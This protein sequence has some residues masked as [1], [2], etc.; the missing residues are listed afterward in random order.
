MFRST[1][2]S[3][4]LG[5]RGRKTG[6][7]LNANVD[8]DAETG[9]PTNVDDLGWSDS[10]SEE[11]E[12]E[13]EEEK[14]KEM[15]PVRKAQLPSASSVS[16]AGILPYSG[17]ALPAKARSTSRES[18]SPGHGTTSARTRTRI[19]RKKK[20]ESAASDTSHQA[21]DTL[22]MEQG[23][24]GLDR[25][26]ERGEE[27]EEDG[28]LSRPL[29]PQGDDSPPSRPLTTLSKKGKGRKRGY[30]GGSMKDPLMKTASEIIEELPSSPSDST[31]GGSVRMSKRRKYAP[32]EWWRNERPIM[33]L[34]EEDNVVVPSVEK[35]VRVPK[36][37]PFHPPQRVQS[38]PSTRGRGRPRKVGRPV[39]IPVLSS[40][41]NGDQEEEK[42]V[43]FLP[44]SVQLKAVQHGGFLFQN[45]FVQQDLMT[46]GV[47]EIPKDGLKPSRN[48]S[49]RVMVYHII[50]GLVEVTLHRTTFALGT[51]AHFFIPPMNQ[52]Q[53][54]NVGRVPCR[55]F[56]CNIYDAPP[57]SEVTTTGPPPLSIK[58]GKGSLGKKGRRMGA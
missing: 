13:E 14:E 21:W 38:A 40:R 24:M 37:D 53:L 12:E 46:A 16:S 41:G 1:T 7:T 8:R 17:S 15:K 42:E 49:N 50:R 52:Y 51:G 30:E 26:E 28:F 57:V 6:R 22:E 19:P 54:R 20:V 11:E 9:L 25:D 56:Y 29:I 2:P 45:L 18:S 44:E 4:T 43:A 33:T 55:L 58:E 48:S 31:S 36:P 3:S 35:V 32:L 34:V 27:D 39:Q 5:I 23:D 47:I 10:S